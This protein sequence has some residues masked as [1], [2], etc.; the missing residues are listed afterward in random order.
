MLAER[1]D[2]PT[3]LPTRDRAAVDGYAVRASDLTRASPSSKVRLA[4]VGSMLPTDHGTDLEVHGREAAYVACGAPMPKGADAVVRVERVRWGGDWIEVSA[5]I[6]CLKNI[7]LAG[8]DLVEGAKV[9]DQGH[10]IR[11]QDIE[12]L[13]SLGITRVKVLR[14]L[15]VA[16]I[17]VGDELVEPRNYVGNRV[18]NSHAYALGTLLE[19]LGVDALQMGVAEDDA[20]KIAERVRESLRLADLVVTIGGCSVGAKDFVPQAIESLEDSKVIFRGV[21]VTAGKPAGLALVGEK[22]VVMLPAHV[23]SMFAGFYLYV[24]PVLNR[25]RALPLRHGL[26]TVK[27]EPAETFQAK[28]HVDTFLL[29]QIQNV[30]GGLVAKPLMGHLSVVQNLLRANAF[31]IVEQGGALSKGQ[32][33]EATLQLGF[34]ARGFR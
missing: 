32:L 23:V 11:P 17:S 16:T 25:L 21:S 6:S 14:R 27:A 1:V 15:K 4:V 12:A 9:I 31:C 33:V 29:L 18:I 2:A 24:V 8:E 7:A 26:A 30:E 13:L 5:P 3:N 20:A 28:P 22:P 10:I 34:G 19:E